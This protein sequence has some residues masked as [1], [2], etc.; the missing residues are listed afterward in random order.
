MAIIY[1][2]GIGQKEVSNQDAKVI[3]QQWENNMLRHDEIISFGNFACKAGSITGITLE[4]ETKDT[5][6]T[7][8]VD[9]SY[10]K[11]RNQIL[12]S[13]LEKRASRVEFYKLFIKIMDDRD[14]TEEEIERVKTIQKDFFEKNPYRLFCDVSLFK[15]LTNKKKAIIG[16]SLHILERIV[17]TDR[18]YEKY[19][20]CSAKV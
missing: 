19:K 20:T 15:D 6:G 9:S 18:S 7:E 16:K 3:K 10:Y 14:T 8:E 12:T 1:L 11:E 5:N 17:Q 13:P 2:R 4:P